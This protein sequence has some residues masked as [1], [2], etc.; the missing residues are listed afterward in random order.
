MI[1]PL[2]QIHPGSV[3]LTMHFRLA[4]LLSGALDKSHYLDFVFMLSGVLTPQFRPTTCGRRSPHKFRLCRAT[5]RREGEGRCKFRCAHHQMPRRT[6][7]TRNGAAPGYP[8]ALRTRP[9]VVLLSA[10]AATGVQHPQ[11]CASHDGIVQRAGK[12]SA[13]SPIFSP[14]DCQARLKTALP[15]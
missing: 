4:W 2:T 1:D 9:A 12:H 6:S 10:T 5:R 11:D 7:E 14:P 3:N 8:T 13:C 15:Q